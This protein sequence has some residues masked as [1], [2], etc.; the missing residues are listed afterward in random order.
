MSLSLFDDP[1]QTGSKYTGRF[2]VKTMSGE[3]LYGEM[4]KFKRF[5]ELVQKD[6][7]VKIEG[8]I[9]ATHQILEMQPEQRKLSDDELRQ[10]LIAFDP[11][12]K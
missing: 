10:N 2:T 1:P 3:T 5:V 9:I 6:K 4:P 7:F 12:K 8:K 11:S